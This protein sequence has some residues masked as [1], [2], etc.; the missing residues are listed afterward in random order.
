MAGGA[1]RG[2]RGRGRRSAGPPLAGRRRRGQGGHVPDDRR[3]PRPSGVRARRGDR[4]LPGAAADPGTPRRGPRDRARALQARARAAR[5]AAVQGGERDVSARVRVLVA[6][7]AVPRPNRRRRS[8][9]RRATAHGTTTP[10]RRSRGPTSSSACSCS[11]VSSS[12]GPS[13]RSSRRSPTDGRSPT[14]ACDTCSISARGLMWSDGTPL[15]AGDIEFGIKRVLDPVDA[16]FVGGDLLRARERPG[17]LPGTQRGRGPGRR[18][19][20]G[21][22]DHRVPAGRSRPVLHERH[23]PAGRRAAATTRDRGRGSVVDGRRVARW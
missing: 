2:T 15:T 20:A 7:R 12:S 3:R 6:S 17:L 5:V 21:R 8:G 22:S 4:S 9:W 13:A 16:R 18:E 23:E 14:T 10:G 19:G 1:V 11:I